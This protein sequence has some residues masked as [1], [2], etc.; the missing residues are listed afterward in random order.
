[1]LGVAQR[2]G[3]GVGGMGLLPDIGGAQHTKS[4]GIGGHDAVLDAV[5]HHLDEMPGTVRPAMQVALLG[6]AADLFAAR[7]ARDVAPSGRE[8]RENRVETSD[9]LGLAPDHHAIA[10]L[11]APHTATGPDIDIMD[12]LWRQLLGPPDVVDIVGIAAVD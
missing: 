4:L 3:L 12:S 8:C 2:R 5:V 7:R 6:G 10:A 11:E 9:H 1:M